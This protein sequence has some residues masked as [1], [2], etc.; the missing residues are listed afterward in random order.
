MNLV[1]FI[2][3]AA[4]L[5]SVAGIVAGK[6]VH[7]SDEFTSSG[8]WIAPKG[9]KAVH[10]EMWGAGGGGGAAYTSTSLEA[11]GG[12]GGAGGYIRGW[13]PVKQKQTYTIT[14]GAAGAGGA[15]EGSPGT[16]GGAS[17]I[18]D[19]A[20][21]V[22]ASAPGG[23][24]GGA[25]SASTGGTAG[26][27]GNPP[28]SDTFLT[29]DGANG[30]AGVPGTFPFGFPAV[31]VQGSVQIYD[32]ATLTISPSSGGQGGFSFTPIG[33]PGGRGHIILSW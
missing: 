28:D 8:T 11:S 17:E 21:V 6:T 26:T 13:V 16:T 19:A 12:G 7:G 9:V 27:G 2:V 32:P 14:V 31:P 29:R 30:T 10:V 4:G 18:L 15:G 24:G 20:S 25:A 23:V 5:F 3:M 1:R 22:L 33:R